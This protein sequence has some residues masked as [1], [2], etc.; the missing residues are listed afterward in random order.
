MAKVEE[1]G[2][3]KVLPLDEPHL[4]RLHETRRRHSEIVAHQDE[5]LHPRAVAMPECLDQF[6]LLEVAPRVEPLLELVD[7]EQHLVRSSEESPLTQ[8]CERG[9]ETEIVREI[10]HPPPKRAEQVHARSASPVASA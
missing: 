10:G 7:H 6:G 3:P 4:E 2:R 9:G 5:T 8:S 1:V